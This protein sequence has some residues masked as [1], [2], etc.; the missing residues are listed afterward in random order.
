MRN[1]YP[2]YCYSC[3]KEVKAGEGYFE[4]YQG[5]WRVKCIECAAKNK[6]EQKKPLTGPQK[7]SLN[8]RNALLWNTELPEDEPD[9]EYWLNYADDHTARSYM[10]VW[11]TD[12]YRPFMTA[13]TEYKNE[14]EFGSPELPNSLLKRAEDFTR[15]FLELHGKINANIILAY[16]MQEWAV[17]DV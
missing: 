11:E 12:W 8:W 4:R 3:N 15:K 14:K 10:N 5:R 17:N 7:N 9:V 1:K 6:Q 13:V 2:G 16:F